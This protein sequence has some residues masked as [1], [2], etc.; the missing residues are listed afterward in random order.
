MTTCGRADATT[1]SSGKSLN[2]SALAL[3]F[4]AATGP[5]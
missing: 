5:I 1:V 4:F 2:I 3:I